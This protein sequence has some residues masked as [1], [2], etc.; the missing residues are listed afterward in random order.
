GLGLLRPLVML[1]AI[2]EG[3]ATRDPEV[4]FRGGLVYAGITVLEQLLGFAQIYSTQILGARAM[5]DLRAEVFRFLGQLP[6]KFFDRQPVGRLVTRVTNDVDSILELFN[7]GAMSAVG[8]LIRLLG[9]VLIMLSLDFRLSLVAFLSLPV[10]G[11]LLVVV[12]RKARVVFRQIRGET[13]RMNANMNEQVA[14]VA[15]VQAYGQEQAMAA[16]FDQINRSYRNANIRSIKYDSIQDAAIDAVSGISM[17]SLVMAMGWSGATFG[18]VVALTVYLK[19]F[20]EPISM[21]AQRYTL[22]QSALSG[23]ERVFGLMKEEERDAPRVIEREPS[24]GSPEYAL[25]FADVT[26]GYKDNL[27]VLHGVSLRARPGESLALVGPTGSGKT[28]ITAILLRLYEARRGSIRVFGRDVSSLTRHELREQFSVVPQDVHL[29]PGTVLENIAVGQKVDAKRANEILQ[30]MGIADLFEARAAGLETVVA[31]GGTNF[32]AGERQLIALARALYRDAPFLILDEA[33]ANID[34]ETEARMQSALR[35]VMEGR[36][37]IIVAHR[38]ST[39]RAASRIIV[40]QKGRVVERGD[41]E[42]LLSQDGLYAALH[43][44]QFE[45]QSRS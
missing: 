41:H 27:D 33:T 10:I 23:A 16:E 20:F 18:T 2:D 9:V 35:A 26:F 43:R 1:K 31:Q 44:L 15:L 6:L 17:A 19:Q 45:H 22:L 5:A 7:S 11:L 29:F 42:S 28:T 38:L 21:L 32:S 14:G 37:S 8:D 3:L 12:R 13:A 36:T 4:I 34:S 40:L 25:E 30:K 24:S 39:I